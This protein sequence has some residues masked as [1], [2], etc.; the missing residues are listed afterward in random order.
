MKKEEPPAKKE[1]P[2]AKKEE[3]PR[4]DPKKPVNNTATQKQSIPKE[5]SKGSLIQY[6]NEKKIE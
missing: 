2:P 3:P 1:E 5:S 6:S 4:P